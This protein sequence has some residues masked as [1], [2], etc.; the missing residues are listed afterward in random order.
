[1]DRTTN[2]LILY[3]LQDHQDDDDL[4]VLDETEDDIDGEK[5]AQ[6]KSSIFNRLGGKV[7]DA[8]NIYVSLY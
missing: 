1:M 5:D 2:V 7:G 4:I 8:S 6:A 3:W